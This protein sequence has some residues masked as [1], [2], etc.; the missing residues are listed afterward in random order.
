M[1]ETYPPIGFGT[2]QL[3][4]ED[5]VAAV[6]AAA[7]EG[8]RLFDTATRYENELEVGL[9]IRKAMYDDEQG[10]PLF[11]RSEILVTSKV[12]V[13]DIGYAKAFKAFNKSC[14]DIGLDYIDNYLI[15]WPRGHYKEAWRAME[16]LRWLGRVRNIGVSN[17]GIDQLKD[18]VSFSISPPTIN[19]VEFH[20]FIFEEQQPLLD[21]CRD[22]GIQVQGYCPLATGIA[23]V[24]DRELLDEI[25]GRYD[26]Q[27][28]QVLV[29]WSMQH[30]VIPLPRSSTPLH[31]A[32][33]FDVFDF[34]LAPEDVL[35]INGLSNGT[36][37]F[38]GP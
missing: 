5:A 12:W 30:G 16:S 29:R 15:H 25:A 18:L 23:S 1:T 36:R 9:A 28:G 19:Q 35:T 22:E 24:K 6:E 4:G 20:P 8:Y 7:R 13:D 37:L 27:V 32:E 38:T 31:I 11:D 34:E 10:Q 26:K 3:K 33:N 17:F 2:G 21:F 14:A